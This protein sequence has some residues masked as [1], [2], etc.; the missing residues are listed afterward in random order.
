MASKSII[1]KLHLIRSNVKFSN[2]YRLFTARISTMGE[3][4]EIKDQTIH[5]EK[6]GSGKHHVFLMPGALGSSRSDFSIQLEK[7]NR[8]K[9][10]LIAWDPPGYGLSRPPDRTFP[11]DFFH[12]DAKMAAELLKTI[13]VE[14]TSVIGWS[15]GGMTALILAAQ[16]PNLMKKL[17]V[18]GANS[19]VT[20]KDI[21]LYEGIRDINKWSQRMKAPMI[22]AYG[23]DYFKK[24]WNQWIDAMILLYKKNQ[25]EVCRKE[26][27][28][29]QC[30]TLIIH[31][32][33]DPMVPRFHP[34]FIKENIKDVT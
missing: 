20:E 27:K 6:V 18:F 26:L 13:G 25:G 21:Q 2:I 31:G 3:N 22:A 1:G 10:T 33:K 11:I 17:V 12:R 5:Y 29:I 16:N 30:P 8:D 34:V 23:E 14:T 24:M 19:Y 9:F 15:D 28:Q 32:A 7:L 4:I